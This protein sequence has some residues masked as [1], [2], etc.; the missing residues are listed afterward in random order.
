M[1]ILT[2]VL[3]LIT[4]FYAWA[5]YKI[6]RANEKI[7]QVMHEQ[8]EAVVRP[9]ISAALALQPDNPIFYL[10]ISNSGKTSAHDLRLTPDRSFFRLGDSSPERDLASYAAF[11]QIIDEFPPESEMVF[12]LAQS[13]KIF[14]E[15]SDDKI[16][17][18]MFSISA[19]YSFGDRT[20]EETYIIDFRPYLGVDI[21]HDPYVTKLKDI[22]KAINK[23]A[24]NVAKKT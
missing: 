13:F 10:R 18:K 21:P 3:V 22:T 24:E 20:V 9:Y 19:K 23:V 16:L 11:N 8:A 2:G 7:V 14:S 17:P 6:L 15:D 12:S 4:A 1:E 5:T